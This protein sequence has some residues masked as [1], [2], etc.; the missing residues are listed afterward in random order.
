[1]I[2]KYY[3][4]E[5]RYLYE[6]GREFAKAH[7][8]RAAYLNIDA[9][10]DRDPSVERL[11]EGFAFLTARIR[12]TIDDTFPELTEGLIQLLWPQ[13]L[14]EIPSTAIVEFSP[15]QGHLQK[16]HR[17][18]RGSQVLS[19]PVGNP[20]VACPFTTTHDLI[21]NPLV[22]SAVAY[23][24]DRQGGSALSLT[25]T[26]EDG[27][28]ASACTLDTLR[29]FLHAEMPIALMLHEFLTSQVTGVTITDVASGTT[30][31]VQ[32]PCPVTPAGLTAAETLLPLDARAFHGYSLLLEYFVCPEKFLFV[33][34]HGLAAF[35]TAFPGLH[36]VRYTIS[37][38][39][40]LPPEK[41]I[42]AE[43]FRLHCT[44][45]INLFS[46]EIEPLTRD[47]RQRSYPLFSGT[48]GYPHSI[49]S[50][51]GIDLTSGVRRPYES[52][53]TFKNLGHAGGPVYIPQYRLAPSGRRELAIGFAGGTILSGGEETISLE[54]RCHN[55]SLPRDELREGDIKFTSPAM[56][57]FIK[58]VNI[59]RP[60]PIGAMPVASDYQWIFLA[61]QGITISS[62]AN[63]DSLRAF[64]R[65]YDRS[66]SEGTAQRIA[67]I[68]EVSCSAAHRIHDAMLIHGSEFTVTFSERGTI[69]PCELRLLGL[70]LSEFLTQFAA[71]NSFVELTF[72]LKPSGATMHWVAHKGIQCPL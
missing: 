53:F 55:G 66:G 26:F 64:L 40:A 18:P 71:I 58:L 42:S 12:E 16:S 32:D 29:I 70:V 51:T 44:P 3:E 69:D 62:L 34:L 41:P 54:A 52:I 9:V 10:G 35:A 47:S 11:F 13:F 2:D 25:L 37:F 23:T 1:M 72:T 21:L 15:R 4:E 28:M 60:T 59:T 63:A 48:A 57:D 49:Q 68:S 38:A 67:A 31:A 5:L 6:S 24:A 14:Q 50:V 43:M 39:Q 19:K 61:H 46:S 65:L 8:D 30:T 17:L 36:E 27:V 20:G 33:D 56:P 45:V 7:P 22:I